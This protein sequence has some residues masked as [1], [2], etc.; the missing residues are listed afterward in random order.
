ML[1]RPKLVGIVGALVA[2]FLVPAVVAASSDGPAVGCHGENAASWTGVDYQTHG[3]GTIVS[4]DGVGFPFWRDLA[5]PAPG[6]APG[7]YAVDTVGYDG[8]PDRENAYQMFEQ[9][10]LEFLD[11]DG[12]VIAT[13]GITDDLPDYVEEVTVPYDVGQ[14]TLDRTAV[15]VRG[16]HAFIGDESSANSVMPVCVGWTLIPEETTTTT[17][18]TTSTTTTQPEE[19]TTTSTTT[20]QPE[21]TTTTTQP[22]ETT[23]TSEAVD[24]TS[25]TTTVAT[26][27]L[28]RVQ[29]MPDPDPVVANPSFTG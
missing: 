11:A 12:V 20:T 15:T 18:S 9:F 13:S 3:S 2:P 28:P 21:E 7:T 5:L 10:K 17:T 22:E 16:I 25:T 14:V 29:E 19:T 4:H 27:V 24:N 23:T 26:R 8:S 6:I 1:S